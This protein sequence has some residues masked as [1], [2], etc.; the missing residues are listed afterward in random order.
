[1]R[2]GFLLVEK[3]KESLMTFRTVLVPALL[4]ASFGLAACMEPGPIRGSIHS[5]SY[6]LRL[7]MTIQDVQDFMGRPPSHISVSP[8][9]GL[10]TCYSYLYDE[11]LKAKF[12]HVKF[13]DNLVIGASDGHRKVCEL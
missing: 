11:M 8:K 9:N 3:R 10:L 12:V 7:G 5:G 2:A 6:K 1:M 4:V 13:E